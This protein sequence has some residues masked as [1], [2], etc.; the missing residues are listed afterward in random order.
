MPLWQKYTLALH[1]Y[2]IKRGFKC[3]GFMEDDPRHGENSEEES[4]TNMTPADAIIM[5]LPLDWTHKNANV[6]SFRYEHSDNP[7]MEQYFKIMHINETTI[8]VNAYQAKK[9]RSN[10][11]QLSSL[12]TAELQTNSSEQSN[13]DNL[14]NWL[15][16]S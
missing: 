9:K 12:L 6:A 11:D 5:A 13:F 4:K 8:E 7:G 3:T 16:K 10:D 2:N 15:P 1:A 14:D